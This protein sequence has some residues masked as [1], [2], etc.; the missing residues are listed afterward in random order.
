M[1]LAVQRKAGWLAMGL[2]PI[3]TLM[4]RRALCV[5][6]LAGTTA[7]CASGGATRPPVVE[8]AAPAAAPVALLPPGEALG[9]RIA[10]TALDLRGI[11]YRNGGT[12]PDGFDCS[13][14]VRYVLAQYGRPLP[15][16]ARDQY[17]TGKRVS[18]DE[19]RA[20]DL[21]FFSTNGPGPSH[22]GIALDGE[23][24]VHAPNS[25]GVVRVE[26]LSTE[27]WRRR[28]LGARRVP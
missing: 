6:V 21:V 19:V 8:P 28:Y 23:E 17:D 20:G 15:R 27:Y 11:P 14:L 9:Y 2:G 16:L 26:R 13:G 4:L 18:R 7:A 24:F 12:T 5:L 1:E 10:A 25:R 3:F 22:V